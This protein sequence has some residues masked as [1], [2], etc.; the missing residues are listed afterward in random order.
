VELLKE[1]IQ[2]CKKCQ[3]LVLSRRQAVPGNGSIPSRV[4][5]VGLAPGRNGAD[6]TGIPFTRD[7]SGILFREMLLQV[8]IDNFFITN[9]VKCNPQDNRGRNRHPST[10][11]IQNCKPYL[12]AEIMMVNPDVIVTLGKT[13]TE[14]FLGTVKAMKKILLK[15]YFSQGRT[16]IPLMHPSYVIRGAYNRTSYIKNF[17]LLKEMIVKCC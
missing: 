16:V 17:L 1:E 10:N 14:Y 13:A 15:K 7:P 3:E 5:F 9:L 11:E 8:C 4:L 6:I 12:D 2:N